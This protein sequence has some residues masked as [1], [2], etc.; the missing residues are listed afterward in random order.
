MNVRKK[1]FE[2]KVNQDYE[3]LWYVPDSNWMSVN[4]FSLHFHSGAV[5]II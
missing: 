2:K 3:L 5:L 1:K 4:Y